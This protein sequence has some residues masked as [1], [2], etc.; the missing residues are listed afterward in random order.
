VLPADPRRS[1]RDRLATPTTLQIKDAARRRL[2][3]GQ[4]AAQR[5]FYLVITATAPPAVA[6]RAINS[7]KVSQV[8]QPTGNPAS[9]SQLTAS[10]GR[11]VWRMAPE[12]PPALRPVALRPPARVAARP[13]PSARRRWLASAPWQLMSE[14]GRP[15]VISP[16]PQPRPQLPSLPPAPAV[17]GAAQATSRLPGH[18]VTGQRR[19]GLCGLPGFDTGR[20]EVRPARRRD[21]AACRHDP[22]PPYR[23]GMQ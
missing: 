7:T 23:M 14:A 6:C 4:S 17:P 1:G 11:W 9:P 21:D 16:C 15:S 18:L 22:L 8:R 10:A 5:A 2:L 20:P 19:D 3:L 12:A 13:A